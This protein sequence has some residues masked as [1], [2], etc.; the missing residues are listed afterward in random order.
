MANWAFNLLCCPSCHGELE[1]PSE[2][3]LQCPACRFTFPVVEGIPVLFPC[4]VKEKI[5]ELFGRMWDS[6]AKAEMYDTLIESGDSIFDKYN[7]E[8]EIYSLVKLID[9]AKVDLV[10]DAGSGNGRFL[11]RFPQGS[12]TVGLDASLEMLIRARRRGRGHFL[13]CGELEHLPFRDGTFDTVISCRVLQ[14][15]KEQQKAVEQ[16]CRVTRP[17]GDVILELYNTWNPKTLYRKIRMSPR[18]RAVLNA[19]FRA[20]FRSIS[21]FGD[22]YLSP[23]D[24]YSGWFQVKRWLRNAKMRGVRGRGVGFGF[25]HYFFE[26]FYID[27]FLSK[28]APSFLRRYYSAAFSTERFL[29]GVRPFTYC[30]EKF[31]IRATKSTGSCLHTAASSNVA[32]SQVLATPIAHPELRRIGMGHDETARPNSGTT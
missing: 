18:V 17:G 10:L 21:P 31:T 5:T 25:H 14:L 1:R 32:P 2:D 6:V 24:K 3:E 13:V 19:P 12:F 11:E 4:N 26:P 7:Y 9:Q 23:H 8:S 28:R 20:V 22:W 15:L 30:M 29:G 27:A 16:L